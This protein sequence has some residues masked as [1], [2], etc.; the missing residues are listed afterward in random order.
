VSKPALKAQNAWWIWSVIVADAL[1]LT[2]ITFPSATEQA[3]SWL[4]SGTRLAGV[5]IAPVIVLLLTSLVPS[6]FKAMLVFWRVRD[7]LPGHRAFS[8]Y[9]EKDSRVDV[10][11]LRAAVGGQFPASPRDQN[12]LWYRL[13]KQVESDPAVM[14]AHRH[15][16]LFRELAAL[17]LLLSVLAASV[18]FLLGAGSAA[19]WGA[20]ALFGIQFLATAIAA[21][22][23]GIRLVCN[24]LAL[25]GAAA[26]PP[27]TKARK[28]RAP[29]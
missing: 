9:A 25:H 4:A 29:R 12:T 18:L 27:S 22:L 23:H 17:S 28:P 11:Q 26:A 16:L 7:V 2:V 15:F 10:E 3:A 14:Q 24:V 6:D 8:I 21:R 1:T 5:S 19:I 13:F 20:L